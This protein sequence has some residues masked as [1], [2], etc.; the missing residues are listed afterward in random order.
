MK[1]K[2]LPPFFIFTAIVW[3]SS[4]VVVQKEVASGPDNQRWDETADFFSEI[5]LMNTI[6]KL[7]SENFAGRLS[8]T[9]EYRNCARWM[10][11]L[12][13][14]W[15]LKPAGDNGS[16]LQSYHNPYTLVF[17]GGKLAYNF[18]S[19]GRWRE[20]RYVY[21]KEYYP[22]SQSGNG[23]LTAEVVYVGYGI[24][25]P[26]I[27]YN[28]YAGVDVQGKIVLVEPGIPI[29]PEKNADLFK[30]WAPL[31]SARLK[32]KMAVAHG[33]KGILFNELRVNPDTEPIK[34]FMAAQIGEDA[35]KDIFSGTGKTQL[36]VIKS[37]KSSLKPQSFRTGK[38]FT[39]DNF[40]EYHAD[41]TGYSVLGWIEGTDPELKEEVIILGAHLD[42]AGFCYEIMPGA[43]DNASGIAALLS[44][45]ESLA[46]GQSELGRSVLFIGIG[47]KEQ[48][49]RGS[50]AYLENPSFPTEKTLVFINLDSIGC[51]DSLE[52]SIS[53]DSP[54]IWEVF[55]QANKI[56][57]QREL[58][59]IPYS[60]LG[61][62][63]TDAEI[64]AKKKIPSISFR[65]YGA[66][67]Y[68]Y[69]T[70]DTAMSLTPDIMKDMG[71]ILFLS[72]LDLA[73]SKKISLN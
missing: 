27:G 14:E 31:S 39:I 64:F 6:E 26:E 71:R 30:A 7:T 16:F 72:I 34:D 20:K 38:S 12:F 70:K 2:L 9:P 13:Q 18:R 52:A 40:T 51:G 44:V 63:Q 65:A 56:T 55:I 25:A 29:S 11:S 35:V 66:P 45:A 67:T 41:G 19:Q 1:R 23:E 59:L 73:N 8:G 17:V 46:K 53:Q 28:D 37:I 54:E 60:D 68:P 24:R 61:I 62:P 33:A 43:N 57:A 5:K 42:G 3:L 4:C 49:F 47:S 32:A 58:K 69:T 36:E 21:E 50:L 22:G 15:E 48:S 10:A